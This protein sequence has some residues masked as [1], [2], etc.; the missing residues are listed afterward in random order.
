MQ[1]ERRKA[2]RVKVNLTARWEGES[3]RGEATVT[4][5]SFTGCFLLSGGT[6]KAKELIR[7]EIDL[8]NEQPLYGW[9]EV[10]DPAEGI[11]FAVKF[12]LVEEDLNRLAAFILRVSR[13]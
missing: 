13:V 11:G 6:V 4:N 8:P 1:Y 5:I 3:D 10:V 7:L 12:T 2:Q 9:A